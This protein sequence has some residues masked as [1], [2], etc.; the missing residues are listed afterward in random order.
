MLIH[1]CLPPKN[2]LASILI[3]ALP[4]QPGVVINY[5]GGRRW[6]DIA[7]Q[8]LTGTGRRMV[9]PNG[10]W[11]AGGGGTEGKEADEDDADETATR[12]HEGH[13]VRVV[14]GFMCM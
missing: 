1:F 7:A 13:I 14:G 8:G 9:G 4:P 10:L 6:I 11:L 5:G 3:F 2:V 12:S